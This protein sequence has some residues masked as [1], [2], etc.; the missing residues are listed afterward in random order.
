MDSTS[1]SWGT[2]FNDMQP[3]KSE[4]PHRYFDINTYE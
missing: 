2:T 4:R 3:T 1:A